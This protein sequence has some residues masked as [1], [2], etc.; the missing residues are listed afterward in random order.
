MEPKAKIKKCA[1]T[2]LLSCCIT[3]PTTRTQ[4][5]TTTYN[6]WHGRQARK[7]NGRAIGAGGDKEGPSSKAVVKADMGFISWQQVTQCS[8]HW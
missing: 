3:T 7:T 4:T 8:C 6:Y 2:H 1:K 5:T